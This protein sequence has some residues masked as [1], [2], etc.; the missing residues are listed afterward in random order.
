M[1]GRDTTS[2]GADAVFRCSLLALAL[3][4]ATDVVVAV[5]DAVEWA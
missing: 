3:A 2:D 5:I 4:A 1:E